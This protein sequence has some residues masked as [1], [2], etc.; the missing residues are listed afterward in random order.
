MCVCY[1]ELTQ[2]IKCVEHLLGSLYWSA[3]N[4][5]PGV[6]EVDAIEATLKASLGGSSKALDQSVA[7]AAQR[8]LQQNIEFVPASKPLS[9]KLRY[10]HI[11]AGCLYLL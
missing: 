10:Y 1:C 2:T 4:R 5:M 3:A 9:L 6:A 7:A 11:V 8:L